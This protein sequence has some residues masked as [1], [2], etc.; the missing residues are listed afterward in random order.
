MILVNMYWTVFSA[1]RLLI[2]VV[3]QLFGL[4]H[5]TFRVQTYTLCLLSGNGTTNQEHPMTLST[6]NL[7]L[8]MQTI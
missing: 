4:N 8:Y 1:R 2:G 6:K 3:W 7:L 5:P